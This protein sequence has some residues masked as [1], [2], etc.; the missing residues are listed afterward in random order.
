MIG[1]RSASLAVRQI[2]VQRREVKEACLGSVIYMNYSSYK[3][4]SF[5]AIAELESKRTVHLRRGNT[6]KYLLSSE[7]TYSNSE[8]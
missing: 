1:G 2:N 7:S 8:I 5:Y 6:A 3:C 4:L